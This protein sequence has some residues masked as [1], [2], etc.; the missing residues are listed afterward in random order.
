MDAVMGIWSIVSKQHPAE[1]QSPKHRAFPSF[2]LSAQRLTVLA[3][4]LA[5]K[6][7]VIN[8]LTMQLVSAPTHLVSPFPYSP[9]LQH[10]SLLPSLC[11]CLLCLPSHQHPQHVAHTSDA[12]FSRQGMVCPHHQFVFRAALCRK[13]CAL[14]NLIC[15]SDPGCAPPAV[16][17]PSVVLLPADPAGCTVLIS[18]EVK[19]WCSVKTSRPQI[20]TGCY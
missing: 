20:N 14:N 1:L 7:A 10:R 13:L 5:I 6:G 12:F 8:D 15:T 18:H 2:C 3:A 9:V 11:G 19:V 16:I 4:F 17:Q